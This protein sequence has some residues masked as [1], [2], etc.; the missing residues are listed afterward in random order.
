[1][2]AWSTPLQ[3]DNRPAY[4]N[5]RMDCA[6]RLTDQQVERYGSQKHCNFF[7]P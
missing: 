3:S 7:T 6:W 5:N 4:G 2:R 1:V